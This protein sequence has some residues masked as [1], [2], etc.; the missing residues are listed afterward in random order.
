MKLF[1]IIG[2]SLSGKTTTV[3]TMIRGL[4]DLGYR[5]GSVKEIHFEQFAID[6]PGSNTVRH[7]EAGSQLVTARGYY[8]TDILYQSKLPL[9][10]ILS[11]YD[12][13]YVALEGV[14]DWLD[15]NPLPTIICAH[16]EQEVRERLH[17]GVFAVSGRIAGQADSVCGLPAYSAL[18]AGEAEILLQLVLRHAVDYMPPLSYTA[19]DA[20]G[21]P[22]ALSMR[23]RL[24]LAAALAEGDI[25]VLRREEHR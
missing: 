20:A 3:E 21:R 15:G 22:V 5:V 17:D 7:R 23:Q 4:R 18:Q 2:V 10:E 11:H 12:Y 8:E 14:S 13:D 19:L 24:L 9:E 16:S 1:S 6:T 25:A